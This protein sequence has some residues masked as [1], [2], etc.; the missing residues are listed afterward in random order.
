MLT[1]N[2]SQFEALAALRCAIGVA[3][4]L[5]IGLAIDQPLVGVF[6]AAGAVGVGF[7]SFQGAYRGRAA[8][9]LLAAVGMAF[10]VFIGSLAGHSTAATIAVA[11]LWAFAGGLLVALGLGASYVGLQS[12]VA[13]LIAGGYPSDL[14]GAAARAALVCGGGLVQTFLVVVIWPL[15][16]FTIERRSIATAYRSLAGYASMIPA[17]EGIPPEPHTFAGMASPFADPQPFA[18]TGEVFVFQA[19]LDEAERIR[20][21]L[22]AFA[23]HDGRLGQADQSC[24]R[25]LAELLAQALTEIAAALEDG[26]EPRERPGF[27]QSL[28]SCVGRGSSGAIVEPLL[29]QIRAA[30]RTAGV[31]T[32][33][34]GHLAPHRE[35]IAKR[36]TRSAVRDGLITLRANLTRQSTAFRHALR[37]AAVLTLTTAGGRVLEL[38]RGYWL[39]LTIAL[40]LK[41]DF[42]DTFAFSIGRV[43][44][45]VLGAAGA[46]AIAYLF[47]PNPSALIALVLAFV[48]GAYG[49]RTANYAA[50][51][52]CI[53]GYVVFLMTLA[54]IPEVTAATD[55]IIYTAIAGVLA[56]CAYVAWPTWTAT[57]ARPAVAAML[58]AQS[59]YVESLLAAYAGP[60]TP[61]MT[62]L[63]EIRASARLARSNSEAVVERMLTEPRSHY[64]M[65]PRTAVGLVAAVRRNALAALSLHAGLERDE[66]GTLPAIRE[67]A[68]QVGSSLM[69][70]ATAVRDRSG[71]PALPPLRQTQLAL[72][73]ASDDGVSDETGLI[74]DSIE[75]MAELLGKDVEG[76]ENNITAAEDV[77]AAR[78]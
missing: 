49:F 21:S 46:T 11:A 40:V 48:W 2:W 68:L 34:P 67:L 4:P 14:E 76:E 64:T 35:H 7:G 58:Q 33:A 17:R 57:E 25:T 63:A 72:A 41:P 77:G 73:R 56:L 45:T 28:A 29:T 78:P 18:R 16:R 65:R 59:R 32:A 43:S 22:A 60:S 30:W 70:L 55:R 8:V 36:P 13:V 12:I 53:T 42:H 44:G 71:R 26:R 9:M 5:L 6:G 19:L 66:H 61:D 39:P 54:G 38:P 15:R 31:L 62:K 24:A 74:V 51:S 50:V 20:A 27:S 3:V 23:V 1:V 75:T 69:T 10:S 37:L 47:A 52:V